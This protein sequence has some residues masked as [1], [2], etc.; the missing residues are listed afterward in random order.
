ME[1]TTEN[2][3]LFENLKSLDSK[4]PDQLLELARLSELAERY[5]E[6]SC[7]MERLVF[8]KAKISETKTAKLEIE[9]RN[10][11]SVAFKNA[12]GHR[13]SSWRQLKSHEPDNNSVIDRAVV[14]EYLAYIEKEM[15]KKCLDIINCV[16]EHVLIKDFAE[17]EEAAQK[18]DLED[19]VFYLKMCGDYFR[20]LSEFKEDQT[21]KD[22]AKKS[23]EDALKLAMDMQ[24]T[25]PTR[26][27]LALNASVCFY[28][29]IGDKQRACSLAKEAF[30]Q[31][32]Q[33][34]DALEDNTYKDSTLIMQ[35]LRDNLTL[36]NA[37]DDNGNMEKEED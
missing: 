23:Y 32:I 7:T 28:E 3:K 14:D 35:L 27:G 2:P 34:L 13:R 30:D 8:Q 19:Q 10:M 31:A 22:N 17:L 21:V 4:K 18:K 12:V 5:D 15:E 33:K 26:L 24:P 11:L 36:W 25:H 20:Y 9:E 1:Q 29:I 16:K 37:E 6:M